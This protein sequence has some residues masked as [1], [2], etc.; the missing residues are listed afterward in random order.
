MVNESTHSKALQNIPLSSILSRML[1]QGLTG[2]KPGV[3]IEPLVY[4]F[5]A[6]DTAARKHTGRGYDAPVQCILPGVAVDS[7]SICQ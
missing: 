7:S 6:I 4:S 3:D 2:A 1:S 5:T